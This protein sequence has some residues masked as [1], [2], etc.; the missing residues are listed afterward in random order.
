M[1]EILALLIIFLK[2]FH[3]SILF[4]MGVDVA[5]GQLGMIA[6]TV[7]VIAYMLFV[8]KWL[9]K[10]KLGYSKLIIILLS[11]FILMGCLMT[12]NKYGYFDDVFQGS[13]LN[14]GSVSICAMLLG[15]EMSQKNRLAKLGKIIPF[16][17]TVFTIVIFITVISGDTG[18]HGL[19]EDSTGLGYQ[20]S[21]YYAA[22]MLGMTLYYLFY[23][24]S[25]EKLGFFER[26]KPLFYIMVLL[27][28]VSVFLAGGRGGLVLAV[29]IV[30][31]FVYKYIKS[32]RLSKK[33][34]VGFYVGAAAVVFFLAFAR[35]ENMGSTDNVAINRLQDFLKSPVD[36]NRSYLWGSAIS[37]FYEHVLFG[38]G[39]GSVY[40]T[41][42]I[43]SHNIFTDILCEGG[44]VGMIIFI[45]I[46]VHAVKNQTMLKRYNKLNS[47]ADVIFL[48]GFTMLLFSDYYL[49]NTMLWFFIGFT[50]TRVVPNNQKGE[51]KH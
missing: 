10:G 33:V 14:F 45:I 30:L 50:M 44:I 31:L 41:I 24:D 36:S 11:V 9:T 20:T 32:K 15:S 40:Y 35:P 8:F 7:S 51:L 5:S 25:L 18:S 16:L 2:P 47:F 46:M 12:V 43:Y 21:A 26:I 19:L 3:S 38:N 34:V 29:L 17:I 28:I 49:S 42:G 23:Y 37:H 39:I 4:F 27:Q 22:F 48:C 13:F 1:I 6:L